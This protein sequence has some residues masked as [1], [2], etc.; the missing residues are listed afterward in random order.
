MKK[1]IVLVGL[2][3]LYGGIAAATG[4]D[5]DFDGNSGFR[6]AGPGG[7]IRSIQLEVPP[8][9]GFSAV[10]AETESPRPL[11]ALLSGCPAQARTEFYKGLFFANGG[12]A[13]AKL[14]IVRSCVSDSTLAAISGVKSKGDDFGKDGYDC[15]CNTSNQLNCKKEKDSTCQEV[16]CWGAC[17]I[18]GRGEFGYV[19]MAQIFTLLPT[20]IAED[21]IGGLTIQGGKVNKISVNEQVLNRLGIEKVAQIME[22]IMK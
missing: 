16:F 20:P 2:I 22:T 18:K 19:D 10:P 4:P 3:C 5:I 13:S 17:T 12:V 15:K 14:E 11:S 9:T 7:I 1:I 6:N 8:A 21:F